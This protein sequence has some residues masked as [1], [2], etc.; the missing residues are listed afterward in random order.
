MPEDTE[1]N[2]AEEEMEQEQEKYQKLPELCQL[3]NNTLLAR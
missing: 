3:A 1:E 2:E